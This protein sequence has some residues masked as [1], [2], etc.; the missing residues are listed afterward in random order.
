[1]SKLLNEY[2]ESKA[3]LDKYKKLESKLR[4]QL[5]EELFPSGEVGTHTAAV[6]GLSI[7]GVFK[8]SYKLDQAEYLNNAEH[9]TDEE[10]ECIK[11]TPSLVLAKYKGLEEDE[12]SVLDD[13]VTVS[14]AM[15]TIKIEVI[16]ES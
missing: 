2:I 12:R 1:M 7:K 15:P 13:C 5:L 4:I 14:H 6:D 16:D 10:M 9:F 8:M 3:R 11:V